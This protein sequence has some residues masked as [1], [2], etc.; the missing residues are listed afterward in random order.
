[1]GLTE[2]INIAF[3]I[4][5]GIFAFVFYLYKNNHKKTER[6]LEQIKN[7]EMKLCRLEVIEQQRNRREN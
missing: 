5:P 4:I 7:M 2:I 6:M 1:M 3:F